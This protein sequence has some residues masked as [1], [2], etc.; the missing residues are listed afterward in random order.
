MG[1]MGSPCEIVDWGSHEMIPAEAIRAAMDA[2]Q[3]TQVQLAERMTAAGDSAVQQ[4]QVSEWLN[5]KTIPTPDTMGRIGEACG[6]RI[7]WEAGKGWW[8]SS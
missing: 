8:V 7:G 5:G 6:V 1:R 3:L 2:A 4:S